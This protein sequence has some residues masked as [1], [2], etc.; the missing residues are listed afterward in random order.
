MA[1]GPWS[2]IA[3]CGVFAVTDFALSVATPGYDAVGETTSQLM[4]E[5][6]RYSVLARVGLATYCVLLVPFVMCVTS[7]FRA[8]QPLTF[9]RT[10]ALWTHIV[11]SF[12]AA[13]F[14]NDSTRV[15]VSGIT[16]N[17]IHDRSAEVL[18]AAAFLAVAATAITARGLGSRR[19][20]W[21][22]VIVAVVMALTGLAM[23]FDISP[24]FTGLEERVGLVAYIIWVAV[25]SQRAVRSRRSRNDSVSEEF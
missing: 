19:I 15:V 25:I 17:S 7:L 1:I 18:F 8:R 21:T 10:G 5:G 2:G 20:A 9:L 6:A 3:A 14:Q 24:A 12:T 22:S 16:V 23:V 4:S 13:S 11:A